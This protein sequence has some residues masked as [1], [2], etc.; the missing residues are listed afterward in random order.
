MKEDQIKEVM[1][2]V[3]T[4]RATGGGIHK[5]A[6]ETK[7]RELLNGAKNGNH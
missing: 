4:Y 6:I 5:H 2:L 7:L 3:D 1:G